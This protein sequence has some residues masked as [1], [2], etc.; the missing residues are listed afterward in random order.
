M[1]VTDLIPDQQSGFDSDGNN[2]ITT[3]SN[4][5][6]DDTP[7]VSFLPTGATDII[8]VSNMQNAAIPSNLRPDIYIKNIKVHLK[9]G[10]LFTN[11]KCRLKVGYHLSG[12]TFFGDYSPYVDIAESDG[13]STTIYTIGNTMGDWNLDW[14]PWT[15][16]GSNL[17]D[18]RCNIYLKK[19]VGSS[20]A[21]AVQATYGMR[22]EVD[23]IPNPETLKIREAKLSLKGGK[24]LIK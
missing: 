21:T 17:V 3:P 23:Y 6:D 2:F 10:W 18:I 4:L 5:K 16:A 15:Q 1:L 13:T 20:S 9:T 7:A 11:T 14:T 12:T 19:G 24:V 22:M 8:Y